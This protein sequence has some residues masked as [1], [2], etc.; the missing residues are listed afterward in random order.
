MFTLFKYLVWL[1]IALSGLMLATISIS[2]FL[3][4]SA[5]D[6]PYD[7]KLTDYVRVLANELRSDDSGVH[8]RPGAVQLLRAD[9]QDR[10]Y[11][12]LRDADGDVIA[13]EPQ[14]AGVAVT[15]TSG[16]PTLQNGQIGEEP[17]R[18][19]SLHVPDPRHPGAS[20]TLQVAE[21][22]NKRHALTEAL[23]TQAVALPQ[24]LVL[25][26]AILLIV[27]GYT[28]VL[29]PMQRLRA[30]IDKRGSGDL[31]PLDPEAA[32][33]DL[34]PL[35]LAINRLMERLSESVAA[36]RRFIADAAHQLRTPLAGIQSQTERALV[37]RDPAAVR[38]AL[39]R[40]AAGTQH[41]TELANRLLTL[42]RA[43]TPLAAP[44][45]AVDLIGIV[46]DTIA[47]HLPQALER[48]HD[49]GFEG[50]TLGP[51]CTVRGDALLLREMLSN[52]IDNALRYSPDGSAITVSID[53][54][55]DS[56]SYVLAVSDTGPG[57]PIAERE[58]VFEPFYRGA[59]VVAS[60]T[61]LGLA[62]V[63]TIA[64]AHGAAVSLAEGEGSQGLRVTVQ[65]PGSMSLAA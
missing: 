10:I 65:F 19:A 21:T 14:M 6:A 29:R 27:Y 24:M 11:Y 53:R 62:I 47:E 44:P 45:V 23:R 59:D 35:I 39:G 3:V 42:A 30:L 46:R 2:E 1:V 25:V 32:P 36:Q 55:P 4:E 26:V 15:L 18:V 37:E 8:V 49:L 54:D 22:L 63:R 52:L 5:I 58:R 50:P 56:G 7:E 28:Y 51:H 12:A 38:M 20:L 48:R 31:S 41:A 34:R 43:G 40:L 33:Q 61:G 13:G 64:T 9:R 60:G 16:V 57:I 17:V